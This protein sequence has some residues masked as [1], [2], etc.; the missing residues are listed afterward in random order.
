[1]DLRIKIIMTIVLVLPMFVAMAPNVQ[2]RACDVNI[3]TG[4]WHAETL[5]GT[6]GFFGNNDNV[7]IE[8]A[9][10]NQYNISD[11]SGGII[12]KFG[13]GNTNPVTIEF[14]CNAHVLP[15]SF[16]TQFG[17]CNILDG[18]WIEEENSLLLIW[19]LPASKVSEVTRYSFN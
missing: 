7:S 4:T 3:P 10:S 6:R 18:T 13:F 9:G 12:A 1:M 16:D 19:E 5:N 15:S 11:F 2:H 14:D 8:N 17:Q